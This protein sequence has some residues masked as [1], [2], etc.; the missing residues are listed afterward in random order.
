MLS[1]RAANPVAAKPIVWRQIA[2]GGQHDLVQRQQASG[3]ETAELERQLLELQIANQAELARA[4][5]SSFEHGLQ[6]GR[7]EAASAI[8]ESAQKLATTLAE[9]VA[10]KRKL[11]LDA[12]R[13][14]VKLSLAIARRILNRELATDPDALEGVVHAALAK[15]QSR[16]VWQV[17]VSPQH[18]EMTK[19]CIERAGLASSVKVHADAALE[20]GDLLIDTHAGELDASVH[21]QLHEIERGFAE[22]LAIR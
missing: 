8:R 18:T 20:P 19:A 9:L 22:R 21:T 2:R 14:V 5:Q 15:L 11:R 7:E 4:K 16:E 3:V 13:E 12:E 1:K 10:F 6:Q 17:R